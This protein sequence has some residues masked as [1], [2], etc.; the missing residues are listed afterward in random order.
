[1]KKTNIFYYA[2]A[3]TLLNP[4][5]S[6]ETQHTSSDQPIHASFVRI[7]LADCPEMKAFDTIIKA[8]PIVLLRLRLITKTAEKIAEKIVS[9][10]TQIAV[11]L[12]PAQEKKLVENFSAEF[13]HCAKDTFDVVR[14]NGSLIL[15]I[16]NKAFGRDQ[17]L[18]ADFISSP[19]DVIDFFHKTVTSLTILKSICDDLAFFSRSIS[20]SISKETEEKVKQYIATLKKQTTGAPQK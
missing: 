18:V 19:L 13:I 3:V 20:V 9:N 16:V 14:K 2:V 5:Y 6:A 17:S 10:E 12:D 7:P 1:M 4:L 11:T 8:S 15:P